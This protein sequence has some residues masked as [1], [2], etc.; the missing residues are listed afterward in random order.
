MM[1]AAARRRELLLGFAT[2]LGVLIILLIFA[3]VLRV[4]VWARPSYWIVNSSLVPAS[5]LLF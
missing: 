5:L 4:N 3:A 1:D 2:Q